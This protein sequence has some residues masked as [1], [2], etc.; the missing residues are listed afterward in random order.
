MQLQL[1]VH[2]LIVLTAAE[3]RELL[4][5]RRSFLSL[6]LYALIILLSVWLLFKVHVTLGS[7][8]GGVDLASADNAEFAT[9]LDKL[10]ARGLVETFL[11][12]SELPSTLWI[13]QIFSLIWFPTLVALVSCD[14]IALD[15]YRGTLRFV[16]SRSS[17]SAYYFSKMLS[18]VVLY[19]VLQAI[20]LLTVVGYS[21]LALEG[22]KWGPAT[23]LALKYFIVFVPFLWCIVAATQF[24]SSWSSRPMN[25]LIRVHVM[26]VG[27]IFMLGF[28]PWASPLWS[29]IGIGLFVPFDNHPFYTLLGYS[30]WGMFFTLVGALFFARRDV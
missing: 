9:T 20:S 16:L 27:F 11:K 1:F 29:K 14:S 19:S 10:G 22:F 23:M 13:F 4:W 6:I 8:H 28:V 15:V 12:L 30:A 17:R 18:H 2:Q 5:R 21:A 26:W 25:A 7:G 24:I 3:L